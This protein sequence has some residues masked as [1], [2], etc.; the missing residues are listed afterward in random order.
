LWRESTF[1]CDID[2][3]DDLAFQLAEIVRNTLLVKRFQVVECRRSSH[4]ESTVW[5]DDVGTIGERCYIG[6]EQR[7]APEMTHESGITI[8]VLL[9]R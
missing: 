6:Q 4:N 9:A 3:K 7:G 5:F 1:G 2:N 8:G